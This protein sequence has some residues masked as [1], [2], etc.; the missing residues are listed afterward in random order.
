MNE[1]MNEPHE[2]VSFLEGFWRVVIALG[3]AILLIYTFYPAF[4]GFHFG[5][6]PLNE[7]NVRVTT[8]GIQ[9]CKHVEKNKTGE[10]SRE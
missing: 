7:D 8:I 10:T 2:F 3:I 5:C 1:P 4:E 9:W 6:N